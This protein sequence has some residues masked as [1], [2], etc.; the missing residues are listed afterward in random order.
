[1][2]D[3]VEQEQGPVAHGLSDEAFLALSD[4]ELATM[5]GE[6]L[7]GSGSEEK[8]PAGEEEDDGTAAVVVDDA[9][10]TDIDDD[11]AGELDED[12]DKDE[13][14]NDNDPELLEADKDPDGDNDSNDDA[15]YS[16]H[17]IADVSIR[18]PIVVSLLI[19]GIGGQAKVSI[20]LLS[21]IRILFRLV[22]PL[23]NPIVS[24]W[25]GSPYRDSL[26]SLSPTF[27]TASFAHS[28]ERKPWKQI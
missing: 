22:E 3:P 18:S 10:D 17:Q 25:L 26:G 4:D 28:G 19:F 1:M 27:L 9:V 23:R 15:D 8:T 13:D 12:K 14:G 16:K 7:S 21:E 11:P 6:L 5:D 2:P 24:L 20:E